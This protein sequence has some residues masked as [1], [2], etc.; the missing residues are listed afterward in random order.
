[1]Q[2]D[3]YR[4]EYDN[5]EENITQDYFIEFDFADIWN[6]EVSCSKNYRNMKYLVNN[7]QMRKINLEL[8]FHAAAFY[9]VHKQ[10]RKDNQN[11]NRPY[12]IQGKEYFPC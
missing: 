12:I 7:I 6:Q 1:M 9:N 4:F 3:V 11:K 2:R 10:M 5:K 8:L